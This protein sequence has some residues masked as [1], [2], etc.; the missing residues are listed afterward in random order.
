MTMKKVGN[1]FE[2]AETQLIKEKKEGRII[3]YDMGDILDYAIQIRK[4]LDR[5]GNLKKVKTFDMKKYKRNYY[6]KHKT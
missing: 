2:L 6:L 1:L 3:C 4:W 5:P